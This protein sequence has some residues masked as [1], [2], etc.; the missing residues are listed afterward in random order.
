[1]VLLVALAF[2]LAGPSA[3]H[4]GVYSTIEAR[5]AVQGSKG[6][7]E[8]LFRLDDKYFTNFL[9][10]TLIPLRRVGTAEADQPWQRWY[11]LTAASVDP[12][13]LD[14]PAGKTAPTPTDLMDIGTALIRMRQYGPAR[15]VLEQARKK[16]KK[17]P[18]ILSTLATAWM[19]LGEYQAAAD[20]LDD[21]TS[22]AWGKSYD[23]LSDA[24]K[25]LFTD[26]MQ[27]TEEFAWYARCEGLH[28]RLA[29]KRRAELKNV[30]LDYTTALLRLDGLFPE[31]G[32]DRKEPPQPV[33]FVGESG[34]FEV[35]KIAAG[36]AA[37]LPREA[38]LMVEQLLMWM[39]ED[40]RLYW[41]LGELFNAHGDTAAA[42]MIFTELLRKYAQHWEPGGASDAG[43]RG[44]Y[45]PSLREHNPD[46]AERIAAYLD[47][48]PP[49]PGGPPSDVG[50]E[51]PPQQQQPQKQP[52]KPTEE[53]VAAVN[54]DWPTL[55]VGFAAGAA[56]GAFAVF[57]V[58][59][60]RRRWQARAASRAAARGAV[61]GGLPQPPHR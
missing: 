41:Q 25:A 1:M 9:Q 20:N 48:E 6:K 36:E 31:P 59:E 29:K 11:A 39:P 56:V 10:S 43:L 47:Y 42:K 51:P 26:T 58:R 12:R 61:P 18:L 17:N 57:Q 35:G 34:K 46:L 13:K 38:I 4:A 23:Q 21:A 27:W 55:G 33:R 22:Y 5:L 37:K 54:L 50:K 45:L 30:P 28:W 32:P 14:A 53:G 8:P 3:A 15:E 24:Q 60:V 49:V 19:Q 16:D 7:G 52:V 44:K 2:A 40:L